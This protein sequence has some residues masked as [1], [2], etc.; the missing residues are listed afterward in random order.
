MY[1]RQ[2]LDRLSGRAAVRH[3]L[4]ALGLRPTDEE[5]DLVLRVIKDQG[6]NDVTDEQLRG[7]ER[8]IRILRAPMEAAP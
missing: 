1:K 7:L 6:M 3:R 2:V 8:T 4:E 5:V